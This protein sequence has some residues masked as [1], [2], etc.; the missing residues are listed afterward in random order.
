MV[1]LSVMAPAQTP[2]PALLSGHFKDDYNINYT[3]TDSVWTQHPKTTYRIVKWNQQEQY[4]IAQNG[5]N[6]KTDAH[7]Y[8]RI[9]YMTFDKME[10][11]RWGFCLT[12]YNAPTPQA[13]EATPPANRQNPRKG[14]NGFPF[15]RMKRMD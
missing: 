5:A 11:Y 2:L 13:A 9:D 15:S 14:C 4:F 12:A 10:P 1:L 8:T 7:L 3:I 6:N